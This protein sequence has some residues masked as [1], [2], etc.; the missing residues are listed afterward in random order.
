MASN[1]PHTDWALP[2]GWTGTPRGIATNLDPQK[3]GIVSCQIVSRKWFFLS[4]K[5]G[6]AVE[7]FSTRREAIAA[8][9]AVEK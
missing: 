4:N 5:G 7:G 1:T 2:E 3:G 9:E 8:C 6:G